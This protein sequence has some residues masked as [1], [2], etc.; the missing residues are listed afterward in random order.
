MAGK[1]GKLAP[2]SNAKTLQ[3]AKYT[4][5]I[6]PDE[7]EKVFREWRIPPNGWGM[8]G[9]DIYGDCTCACPAHMEMLWT[10]H[11]NGLYVPSEESILAA[12]SAVTGFSVG[13]PPVND[14]GAAITDV[15]DYW[16]TTGI[17]GKKIV[18]WAQIDQTNVKA[19]KQAIWLFGGINIGINLPN[20]AMT[21]FDQ[22]L[23]WVILPNDGGIDGGHCIPLEGYGSEGTSCIT[24]GRRQ[25]MNWDWF[26]K[27]C[28]EAY[29][30]ITMDWIIQNTGKTP[31]GFDLATLE[32]DLNALKA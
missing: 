26:L 23:P 22:N 10:E 3:L 2:K 29:A 16:R 4:A 28:D 20:S 15:L 1:L 30:V 7:P 21:Q 25:G 31:S 11:S 8:Y 24:W 27:Y 9:N 32:F 18:G 5:N 19:I 13:P 17:A 14:N 6:I 12:Y